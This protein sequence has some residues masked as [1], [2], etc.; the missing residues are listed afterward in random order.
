M[1]DFFIALADLVRALLEAN[2]PLKV[3][4]P[5]DRTTDHLEGGAD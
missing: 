2:Q 4:P 5:S 1:H 3:T